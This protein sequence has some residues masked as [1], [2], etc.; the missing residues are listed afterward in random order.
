M[1]SIRSCLNGTRSAMQPGE[2]TSKGTRVSFVYY[3]QKWPYEKSLGTYLMILVYI[4]VCV[5]V[6]VCVFVCVYMYLNY[7]HQVTKRVRI[8]LTLSPR[9]YSYS[10]LPVGL[11]DYILRLRTTVVGKFLRVGQH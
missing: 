2:I 10:P 8:S 3:Q 5:R 1:G 11:P 9:S 7:H 6:C 4:Y